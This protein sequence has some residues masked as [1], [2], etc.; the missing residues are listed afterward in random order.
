MLGA[1]AAAASAGRPRSWPAHGPVCTS[2]STRATRPPMAGTACALWRCEPQ[3][4]ASRSAP[5]Q[6]ACMWSSCWMAAARSLKVRRAGPCTGAC[7][8]QAGILYIFT[9]PVCSVHRAERDLE[10]VSDRGGASSA[11]LRC[12]KTFLSFVKSH[13]RQPLSFDLTEAE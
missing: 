5:W 8:N 6:G 13:A 12:F 10:R 1:L 3:P 2:S 4:R 11:V 7:R 9:T